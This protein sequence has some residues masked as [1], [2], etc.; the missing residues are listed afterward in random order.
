MAVGLFGGAFDPPHDGH[1]ALARAA[2]THFGL[3]QLIVLVAEAPGHK[4]VELPAAIRLELARA[5]FPDDDVRLDPHARTIDLLREEDFDD[6]IF[7]IGG[8]QFVDFLTW[9]EPQE[10][11]ELA[12]LGVATRPGFD[13]GLLDT[14]LRSLGRAD[15]VEFFDIEPT[16]V[17]SSEIRILAAEGAPLTGL[18]PD[19]VERLIRD[20]GLYVRRPWL[21]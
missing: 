20:R 5:A 18:V 13:A 11:L 4:D 12:R 19:A 6:P 17:A 7:L 3:P 1:V 21:D 14:V 10:V 15:R 9:K 16:P 8:D 2:K